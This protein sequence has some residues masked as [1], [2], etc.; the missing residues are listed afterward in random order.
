MRNYSRRTCLKMAGTAW[1]TP[2]FV[3]DSILGKTAQSLPSERI[4]LGVI[5]VGGQGTVYVS[6]LTGNKE[7]CIIAVCDPQKNNRENAKR[8]VETAYASDTKS[9]I[10]NGCCAYHDFRDLLTRTD[11]DAVFIASSEHRHA[12]IAIAAARARKDNDT[13]YSGPIEIT[14]KGVF[15]QKG[16]N[17]PPISWHTEFTYANGVR[18][19]FTTT[20]E[21]RFGILFEGMQGWVFVDRD[22]IEASPISLLKTNFA[23]KDIRLY[24]SNNH[25]Q[26]F[27]DCIRTCRD[28]IYPVGVGHRAAMICNLSDI[29]LR[30]G[31]KLYW[32]PEKECFINDEQADRLMSRTMRSPWRL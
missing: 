8:L 22:K 28:T 10:F 13:D 7:I 12:L 3:P 26:N 25:Q 29:A 32:N 1:V 15:P 5:G 21:N 31:R 4:T 14:G 19:I 2:Y 11:I 18:L 16:I 30:L 23:P 6:V 20:N 24:Q 27:I 17:D 9:G